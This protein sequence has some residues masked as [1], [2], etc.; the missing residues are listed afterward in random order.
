LTVLGLIGGLYFTS[1]ANEHDDN[2]RAQALLLGESGCGAS[3]ML[4]DDCRQLWDEQVDER[5]ARRLATASFIGFGVGAAATLGYGLWLLLD[6]DD[7]KPKASTSQARGV[8]PSIELKSGGAT[9]RLH[10]QF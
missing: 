3:T 2:A 10:G 1:S 5:N 9:L 4:M 6:E 8:Q 7:A